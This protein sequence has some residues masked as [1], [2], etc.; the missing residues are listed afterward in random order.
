MR[1]PR[2]TTQHVTAD[3]ARTAVE[4]VIAEAGFAVE[5]VTNDYGEDLLV[6]TSHA[7][8]MDASR[9]WLQVKGTEDS[10]Q[11]RR[12]TGSFAYSVPIGHAIR[13]LRS[14]DLVIVVLWDVVK[15]TGRYAVV[16]EEVDEW[17]SAQAGTPTLLL[18]FSADHVFNVSAARS[19]AWQSRIMRYS[20]LF[21]HAQEVERSAREEESLFSADRSG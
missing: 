12:A 14:G 17:G 2:R 20:A 18:S 7:G 16:S 11:Y 21:L 8:Q 9:M 5:V 1:V 6:Q 13:W 4:A 10:R 19:L 3:R 15:R